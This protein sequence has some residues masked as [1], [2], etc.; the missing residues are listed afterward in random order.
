MM[1]QK[2][3]LAYDKGK[4]QTRLE[5]VQAQLEQCAGASAELQTLQRAHAALDAKH[6]KVGRLCTC[7]N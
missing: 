5:Q 6:N 3:K 4:L 7:A 2:N 1:E